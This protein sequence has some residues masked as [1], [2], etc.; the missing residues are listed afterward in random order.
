MMTDPDL[1]RFVT[2]VAMD[3][4]V[5]SVRVEQSGAI[6][7]AHEVLDRFRNPHIVHPLINITLQYSS[8]MAMRNVQTLLNYVADHNAVPKF[9]SLG[10]AAYIVFSKVEHEEKGNYFGQREDEEYSIN[11]D[12]GNL[13]AKHWQEFEGDT[14]VLVSGLLGEVSI[15]GQ[16]LNDVPNFGVTVCYYIDL[17]LEKGAQ[18]A[19]EEI[20]GIQ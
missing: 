19:L 2:H 8:K 17:L 12:K 18:A 20:L 13:L 1:E 5:P 15:W 7:F 9:F 10:F 6:Q 4:M 11:D 16:N 3:E 14:S